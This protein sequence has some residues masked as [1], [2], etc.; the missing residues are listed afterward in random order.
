MSNLLRRRDIRD[1]I[2][3]FGI[4]LIA[5][6][7][8]NYYDLSAK[9]FQLALDYADWEVDNLILMSVVS[10]IALIIY[11]FRRNQDLSRE[12]K[13]RRSA[14][15][16]ARNLTRQAVDKAG[17]EAET[18]HT[19]R[20]TAAAARRS[21]MQRLADDFEA[22]VGGIVEAVSSSANELEA[23]AGTLSNTA[24]RTQQLSAAV[25][26][27]SGQVSSNV[28]SVAAVTDE[29]ARSVNE[30][31]RQVQDSSRIA[32]MAVKQVEETDAR[33]TTLSQAANRIGDVV[34]LIAAI[35]GQTNLLALNATI[36]AAR[37][38]ES[39]KGFAVVAQEV[40][41]LAAQT[42]KATEEIRTQVANMQAATQ[43]SVVAIKE[44]GGTIGRISVI[45][46]TIVAAV[47]GQ[48]AATQNIAHTVQQAVQG[49][50]QVA[51]NISEVDRGA[52]ETGAASSLVLVSA[53]SLSGEGNKLKA[54]MDKFLATVHAA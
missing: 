25:A 33:I 30:I 9:I 4:T 45:A 36:E 21:D 24:E 23:A 14:E 19:R 12:I 40:K 28:Q 43:E 52:S 2:V 26:A 8:A 31:S 16:E 32:R 54:E 47:E 46:S 41:A 22:A 39:G 37:A 20:E 49:T 29:M 13:A 42:A 48:D 50:S 6:A 53:R 1:A 15:L 7:Y 44:I 51:D 11:G 34:K 38:G 18:R 35:A 27:T 10:S 3:L 5:F 17:E